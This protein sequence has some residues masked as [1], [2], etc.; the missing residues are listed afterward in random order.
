MGPTAALVAWQQARDARATGADPAASRKSDRHDQRRLAQRVRKERAQTGY[1]VRRLAD[2]Y[3]SSYAGTVAPKTFA[4]LE[5]LPARERDPPIAD[6]PASALSQAEV[7]ALLRFLPNFSRDVEDTL[8]YLWTDAAGRPGS[9][10]GHQSRMP[11]ST[12]MT[13]PFR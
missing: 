9:A 8:L 10:I 5:R 12:S 3:L 2:D 1:T 11:P 13:A 4:E 6:A 7:S